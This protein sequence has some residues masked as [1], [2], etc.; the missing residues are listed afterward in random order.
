MDNN[1]LISV[2]VPVYRV[3]KYLDKCVSS[4]VSQSYGNLEIILVD[5]GSPDKCGAMCDAWEKKDSRIRVIH[6]ENGGLSDARNAGI[7][8][9][10]GE[11]LMFVDSDDYIAPDMAEKLHTALVKNEA[12]LS[13]CN[14]CCVSEEGTEDFEQPNRLQEKLI[15]GEDALALLL[16][17]GSVNYVVAWNKLYKR[18][19]FHELRFPRGKYHE[20]EFLAHHILGLCKRIAC[21]PDVLYFYL[22]RDGSIMSNPSFIR[23]L[24]SLEAAADRIQYCEASGMAKMLGMYYMNLSADFS[25]LCE[26]KEDVEQNREEVSAFFQQIRSMRH[27]AAYCPLKQKICIYLMCIHP[28]LFRMIFKLVNPS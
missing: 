28:A 19:L 16:A 11:C 27:L 18:E 13:I 17:R 6:K 8:A 2:I 4:I 15:T 26:C 24:H 10:N 21:I 3:E 7:E 25:F 23:R 20:D 9:A 5:D 22:Q 1:S 12:E 14:F